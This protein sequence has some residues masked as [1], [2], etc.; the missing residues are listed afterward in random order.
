[1]RK[2]LLACAVIAALSGVALADWD[3]GVEVQGASPA[4][5]P[6]DHWAYD[7][8]NDLYEAGL[9]EGYPDGTFRGDNHLTRYEF[10]MALARLLWHFDDQIGQ[11]EPQPGREGEPGA[12]GPAGKDGP[13]GPKGAPGDPGPKGE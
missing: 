8:V 10:A 12:E 5:V 11:I 7:A 2:A 13:P 9:L 4:D 3:V 6:W 1:M